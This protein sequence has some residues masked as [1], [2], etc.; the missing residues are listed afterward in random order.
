MHKFTA[1]K[2]CAILIFAIAIQSAQKIHYNS[3]IQVSCQQSKIK[4]QSLHLLTSQILHMINHYKLLHNH[5]LAF[6]LL[7]V[8]LGAGDGRSGYGTSLSLFEGA[9]NWPIFDLATAA[10]RHTNAD[11]TADTATIIMDMLT[12]RTTTGVE[13]QRRPSEF[14]VAVID[15]ESS[16]V[17]GR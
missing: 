10:V 3:P 4:K 17:A 6:A 11:T 1:L 7:L 8:P 9:K 5:T 2:N 15:T 12:K 13:T 16:C 14:V